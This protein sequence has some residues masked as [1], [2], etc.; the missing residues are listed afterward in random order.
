MLT[1]RGLEILDTLDELV[2]PEHTALLLWDLARPQVSGA[3]NSATLVPAAAKLI[4]A[5]HDHGVPV[6]YSHPSNMAV[7]GDTGAPTIRMRGRQST[8]FT[9]RDPARTRHGVDEIVPELHP[10]DGDIALPRIGPNGFMGTSLD[11]RLRRLGITTL[12]VGGINIRTGV[13]GSARE[14]INHGYYAVIVED[15][16]GTGD[17]EQYES[18]IALMRNLFDVYTSSEIIDSWARGR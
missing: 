4:A 6:I 5:A 11:W 14:A 12:L 16:A 3:F 13:L 10:R 18:T 2:A 17:P 8:D 7:I 9:R 15:C 1:Y